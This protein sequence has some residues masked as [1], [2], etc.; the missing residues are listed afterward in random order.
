[1]D[2]AWVTT[3]LLNVLSNLPQSMRSSVGELLMTASGTTEVWIPGVMAFWVGLLL[4]CVW[5]VMTY[6][7]KDKHDRW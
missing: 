2:E 3:E 4:A 7:G 1:M 6:M 5:V